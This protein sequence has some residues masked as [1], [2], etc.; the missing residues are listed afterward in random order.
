[1]YENDFQK[2]ALFRRGPFSVN[3][4]QLCATRKGTCAEIYDYIHMY[5][6]HI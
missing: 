3:P 1:M 6:V 2:L 4:C 5:I